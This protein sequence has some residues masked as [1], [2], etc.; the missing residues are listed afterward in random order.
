M[1]PPTPEHLKTQDE[2]ELDEFLVFWPNRVTLT[3]LWY[4]APRGVERLLTGL[5][6]LARY[7]P[8]VLGWIGFDLALFWLYDTGHYNDPLHVMAKEHWWLLPLFWQGMMYFV[9]RV[10]VWGLA[11]VLFLLPISIG[12][13]LFWVWKSFFA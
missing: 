11:Y 5:Y 10:I 7:L 4:L 9:G 2:K 12:T 1:L 8:T 13:I 3:I 6:F